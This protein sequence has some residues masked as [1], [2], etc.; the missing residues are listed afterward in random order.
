MTMKQAKTLPV[1]MRVAH[2][3]LTGPFPMGSVI[4]NDAKSVLIHWD[5]GLEARL[6][7]RDAAR[8]FCPGL[9]G[10]K[11]PRKRG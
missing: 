2:Y 11:T 9:P 5:D 6:M 1:G 10:T 4:S 7:H 8:I 3:V